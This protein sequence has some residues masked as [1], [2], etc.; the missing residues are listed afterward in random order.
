MFFNFVYNLASSEVNGT[1]PCSFIFS[2]SFVIVVLIFPQQSRFPFV[3]QNLIGAHLSSR[4]LETVRDVDEGLGFALARCAVRHGRRRL[5]VGGL[6]ISVLECASNSL[7]KQN[8]KYEWTLDRSLMQ[9]I[10]DS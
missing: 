6:L 5:H 7:Y 9:E 3:L 1:Q 2:E 8:I 4:E 10:F